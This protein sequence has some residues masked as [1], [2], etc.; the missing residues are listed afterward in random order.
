[1]ISSSS[2]QFNSS[3]K[4]ASSGFGQQGF[5]SS[6]DQLAGKILK[7]AD[8]VKIENFKQILLGRCRKKKANQTNRLG[9]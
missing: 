6:A 2:Q 5:P 3:N 1:L 8:F 4:Q 7:I 9:R